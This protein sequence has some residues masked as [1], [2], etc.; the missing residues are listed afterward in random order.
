M[1]EFLFYFVAIICVIALLK[2]DF[3][4]LFRRENN[5]R[6]YRR[7]N[8]HHNRNINLEDVYCPECGSPNVTVHSDGS[9]EC[10]DCQFR[11]Y[12]SNRV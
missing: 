2:E 8:Y 4:G 12:L 3:P 1:L 10:E 5:Q 6:N 9:C 11:F 7:K